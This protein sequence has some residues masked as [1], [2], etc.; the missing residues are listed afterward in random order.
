MMSRKVTYTNSAKVSSPTTSD[1][2]NS[3]ADNN[4]SSNNSNNLGSP[5]RSA[6]QRGGMHSLAEYH[7]D[8]QLKMPQQQQQLYSEEP[9][10]SSPNPGTPARPRVYL[11][12]NSDSVLSR[13]GGYSNSRSG[14]G[15][16]AGYHSGGG[17]E[18]GSLPTS[19][20]SRSRDT[21]EQVTSLVRLCSLCSS[22]VCCV[23]CKLT[24]LLIALFR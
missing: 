16:P 23:G 24:R 2:S 14:N 22:W 10:S 17:A 19:S 5:G 8:F 3:S 15:S 12:S 9:V 4:Y 7:Q 21:P 1:G 11:H 13:S 18:S 20:I 6:G